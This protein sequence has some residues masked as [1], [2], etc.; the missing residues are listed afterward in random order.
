[1]RPSASIAGGALLEV[2]HLAISIGGVA[3]TRDVSFA[4]ARG[5][6]VGMVGESGCGKTITGLSLMRL[7]PRQM[8]IEGRVAFE[9]TDL[10][11]LPARAM[12]GVRGRRIGMIFQEPMSA[13]DPV[14][15]VG[16]Q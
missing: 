9:G 2:E 4:I 13:L 7:L 5:E 6:R 10:L 14:F 11:R 3:L 15:T 8:R 16:E 12:G 1:M